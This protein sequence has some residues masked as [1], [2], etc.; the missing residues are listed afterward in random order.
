MGSEITRNRVQG[1][2]PGQAL[3]GQEGKVGGHLS[4]STQ[5]QSLLLLEEGAEDPSRA[6]W[7]CGLNPHLDCAEP[8]AFYGVFMSSRAGLSEFHISGTWDSGSSVSRLS[9]FFRSC[10]LNVDSVPGFCP[11]L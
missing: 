11:L 3:D 8:P 5:I 9:C 7:E 10:L 2:A 6:E 1:R 4:C